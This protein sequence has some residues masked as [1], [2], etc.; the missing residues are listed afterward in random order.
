MFPNQWLL[1]KR[2]IVSRNAS[3]INSLLALFPPLSQAGML[4]ERVFQQTQ[5]ADSFVVVK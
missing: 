5:I 2:T 1:Y 3:P 4:S